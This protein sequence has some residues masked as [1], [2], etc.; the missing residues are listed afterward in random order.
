M[1]RW[2]QGPS[3]WSRDSR[4]SREVLAPRG[5]GVDGSLDVL[6]ILKAG[7]SGIL[8]PGGWGDWYPGGVGPG[9]VGGTHV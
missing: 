6:F 1:I 3:T 8:L 7:A 4:D 9:G 2:T 5:A